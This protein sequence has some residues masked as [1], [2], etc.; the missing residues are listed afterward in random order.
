MLMVTNVNYKPSR[1][2]LYMLNYII[3]HRYRS[4]N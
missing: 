4:L 3:K 1:L 2:P